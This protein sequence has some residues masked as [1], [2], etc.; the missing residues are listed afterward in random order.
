MLIAVNGVELA[1]S[2]H[3]EGDALLLVHGFTGNAGDWSGVVE[4]LA[5]D[6]RVITVEHRGHGA[7]T[8]TGDLAT[9]TFD[10]L[11]DDLAVMVDL[12][13]LDR[14]DLLGHSMGGI[15][16]QRYAL[17]SP[18]RVRSLVLMDTGG[19]PDPEGTSS[20]FMRAGIERA[21]TGGTMAVYDEIAP[22]LG[23]GAEGDVLRAGLR[24]NFE[25]LD[26]V[27][28]VALGEELL[29]Y[30]SMLDE[31]AGLAVPTTVLVGE[32]DVGLRTAADDL[33]ATIP[34]AVLVVIPDAGHSP[35]VD[36]RGAW[37]DA[38]EAHLARRA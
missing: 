9:Y 14:F 15:V 11:V 20:A 2:S 10:Q 27:A 17:R 28:F 37:L 16:S 4:H 29:T 30:R 35:Q 34:G 8:N 32:N 36:N 1:V 7:S 3:G 33:A 6:R 18:D 26:P 5:A 38:V 13:E 22:Y 23:E 19:R 21:R 31:L 25:C 24:R 12:L